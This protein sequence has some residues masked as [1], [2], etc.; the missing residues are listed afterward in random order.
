LVLSEIAVEAELV[1]D[2]APENFGICLVERPQV[3]AFEVLMAEYGAAIR[4]ITTKFQNLD[5]DAKIRLGHSPI[6]GITSRLKSPE[7]LYEKLGR[8]GFPATLGSIRKNIFDVAGVRVVCNYVEDVYTVERELLNQADVK[9]VQRKDYIAHPKESGYRSLHIV[10]CIPVYLN[11]TCRE[12]NVE[13]QLRTIA[14]DFWS[15]LEHTLRYKNQWVVESNTPAM[16]EIRR[17]LHDCAER[18]AV[19][20]EDMQRLQDGITTLKAEQGRQG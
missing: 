5:E 18:I 15:S 1:E 20:D 19:I 14:M 9:L 7:S 6:H 11:G 13:V 10:V 8:K 12:V 3:H 2:G 16:V 4:E 17:S